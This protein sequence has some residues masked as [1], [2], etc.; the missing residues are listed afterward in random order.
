MTTPNYAV[1]F[2]CRDAATLANFWSQAIDRPVDDGATPGF[3]SIGL[4]EPNDG[5]IRMMFNKVPE[6][7]SVKNRVHLDLFSPDVDGTVRRLVSLGASKGQEFNDGGGRWITLADPEDNEFDVVAEQVEARSSGREHTNCRRSAPGERGELITTPIRGRGR[8]CVVR[9]RS[10]SLWNRLNSSR[11]RHSSVTAESGNS[12]AR[13]LDRLP[14]A[15]EAAPPP[16]TC[17]AVDGIAALPAGSAVEFSDTHVDL[18][19][20]R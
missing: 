2:D 9:H 6:R 13:V 7:K 16:Q 15:V 19:G 18:S 1:T 14:D 12:R 5:H 4:Q 3:A 20:L 10:R 8:V 11:Y 17:T